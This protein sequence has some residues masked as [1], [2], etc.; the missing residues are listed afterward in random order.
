MQLVK[1][2]FIT[3]ACPKCKQP[4]AVMEW[5]GHV[6]FLV[7]D[8]MDCELWRRPQRRKY[9]RRLYYDSIWEY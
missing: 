3:D 9:K 2:N 5:N 6:D 4:L 8:N 7:C 1:T